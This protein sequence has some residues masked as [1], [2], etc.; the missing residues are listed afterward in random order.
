MWNWK[1][2]NRNLQMTTRRPQPF[3]EETHSMMG[4]QD[5]LKTMIPSTRAREAHEPD[6]GLI[7]KIRHRLFNRISGK[8]KTDQLQ[9]N[10]GDE[11][12]TLSS[13]AF[14]NNLQTNVPLYSLGNE[15]DMNVPAPDGTPMAAG[16]AGNDLFSAVPLYSIENAQ[17]SV[18]P[19]YSLEDMQNMNVPGLDGTPMAAGTAWNDL[20]SAV[21]LYSIENAQNSVAPT[22]SLDDTQNMNVPAPDGTPMAFGESLF[23]GGNPALNRRV[24]VGSHRNKR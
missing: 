17:N 3:H 10:L 7:D 19:T 14:G 23:G 15:Q 21:P 4:N 22:Y 11:S 8:S 20:F 6:K 5:L 2:A 16:Q 9:T 12:P 13:S 24:T 1:S 18:A